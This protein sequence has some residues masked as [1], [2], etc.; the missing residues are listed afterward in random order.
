MLD[1]GGSY[2]D[3]EAYLAPLLS[4]S[5]ATGEICHRG[6][7]V[8]SGSFWTRPGLEQ[9]LR[10]SDALH[11]AERQSQ[12]LAI[13]ATAAAGAAYLPVWLVTPK[14]SAQPHLAPPEFNGSGQLRL[15]RLEAKR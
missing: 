7:A 6:E 1:W 14:A 5:Q 3:P 12:L 4:C 9:A 13:D 8:I 15:A 11:G 2:P 10:A